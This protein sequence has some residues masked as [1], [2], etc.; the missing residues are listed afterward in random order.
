MMKSAQQFHATTLRRHALS[1]T[2]S[3]INT[4]DFLKESVAFLSECIYHYV[5]KHAFGKQ[6]THLN[7]STLPL[8]REQPTADTQSGP[9]LAAAPPSKPGLAG[10]VI[11][12][13]HGKLLEEDIRQIKQLLQSRPAN[14]ALLEKMALYHALYIVWPSKKE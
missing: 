14:K 1:S 7:K 5:T 12:D 11:S 3:V 8:F 6:R 13:R 10:D 9:G 4:A 2:L